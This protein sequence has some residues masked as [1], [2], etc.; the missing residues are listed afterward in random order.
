MRPLRHL[1]FLCTGNYY[2]SRFAEELWRHLEQGE[3]APWP[4]YSAGL[5]VALGQWNIGPMSPSALEGLAVRGVHV[6]T[7]RVPRPAVADDFAGADHVVA[8]SESEHR[9]MIAR[10]FPEWVDRV[11]YWAIDDVDLCPPE[12]ALEQLDAAIRELRRRLRARRGD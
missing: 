4:A 5:D 1:L 3:E 7:P 12:V 9:V 6:A 8:M 10:R 2:R 11:E